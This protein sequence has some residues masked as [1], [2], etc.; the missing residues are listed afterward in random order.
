MLSRSSFTLSRRAFSS[1]P[2]NQ[3]ASVLKLNVGDEATAIKLDT[4]VKKLND[5]MKKHPG[6]GSTTRYVCKS[7]WAYELSFVFGSGE[8]FGAWKEC[9]LR[10][11]VHAEYLSALADCGIK[12]ED[13][14]GGARVHDV[15]E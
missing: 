1:I 8:S 3:V 2:V 13:V 10:N 15:L 12:E 5:M 14:Y 6:F 9:A 11:E 4:H 7:E